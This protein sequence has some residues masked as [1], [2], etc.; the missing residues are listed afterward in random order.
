MQQQQR[1]VRLY[2]ALRGALGGA[3]CSSEVLANVAKGHSHLWLSSSKAPAWQQALRLGTAQQQAG[4]SSSSKSAAAWYG[5]AARR[6]LST[7]VADAGAVAAKGSS[8]TASAA[9]KVVSPSIA[10][11]KGLPNSARKQLAW[12]LGG[13]SA[14]V[15]SMVVLGGV[16][17]LTRS[18]LSMTD[19]KFTGERPP[20]TQE[21]WLAEFAKYQQSP[22]F[23]LAHSHMSVEDFKFIYYMEWAHRMWGRILGL[24][25]AVPATYFAARG[26]I[27]G[28]LGKRLGICFLMGGAQGLVGWWMV[29]S[30]LQVGDDGKL[31][32][33]LSKSVDHSEQCAV[34]L[35]KCM[36]L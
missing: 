21:E 22:E 28:P 1:A 26:Y 18:G 29:R 19:W 30:G 12:W 11:S 32:L 33:L 25:F 2:S 3:G 20:I 13:C 27:N 14:W 9:V 8:S 34:W 35:V 24:A 10:L 7:A 6:L 4:I 5:L 17:R 23:R 36:V 16:T 15:F 31:Q